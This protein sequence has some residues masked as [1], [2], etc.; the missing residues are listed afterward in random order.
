MLIRLPDSYSFDDATQLGISALTTCQL[1]WES[2]PDLPKPFEDTKSSEQPT[3]LVWGGA[4]ATGHYVIQYAKLA[5]IK[6]ITTASPKHFDRLKELGADLCFDYNDPE[7]VTKIRE[8]AG[9]KLKHAADCMS[10]EETLKLVNDCTGDEGGVISGFL[11]GPREGVNIKEGVIVKASMVYNLLG[12]VR[13][14]A[15][16][17]LCPSLIVG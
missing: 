15:I 4:T 7:V 12:E 2:Q 14:F 9:R 8:V 10:V 3:L 13:S 1:L 11:G 5:G 6:V 17:A 16:A